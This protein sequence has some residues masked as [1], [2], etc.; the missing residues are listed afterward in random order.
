MKHIFV[1]CMLTICNVRKA[2]ICFYVY[3]I[4]N[5]PTTWF[6]RY[7][8]ANN[9]KMLHAIR[10]NAT[11]M[12]PASYPLKFWIKL[13]ISLYHIN[14]LSASHSCERRTPLT[15]RVQRSDRIH[16]IQRGNC[17]NLRFLRWSSS[18]EFIAIGIRVYTRWNIFVV[19][20]SVPWE[21]LRILYDIENINYMS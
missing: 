16:Y 14:N 17:S 18:S 1:D 5:I 9:T 4:K 21:L 15:K 19:L 7:F 11:T 3:F 8:F 20:K 6:Y 13:C 12:G 2:W 10:V